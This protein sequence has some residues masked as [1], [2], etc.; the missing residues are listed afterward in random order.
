MKTALFFLLDK[1]ADWEV[2]YLASRLNVNLDWEVKTVSLQKDTSISSMGGFRTLIDYH[3][4]DLPMDADLLVLIGGNCWGLENIK[5][6]QL[7]DHFLKQGTCVAAICGAVDFLARYGH[8]NRFKHTGNTSYLWADY[9][10]YRNQTEFLSEQVVVDRNLITANGTAA[11]EFSE[12]I[13]KTLK[14]A[15]NEQIEKEHK[16]FAMGYYNYVEKYGNPFA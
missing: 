10:N 15:S 2:G 13:L 1:Y 11:I 9:E 6:S 8:L 7:I 3:V 14:F 12:Q 4:D 5:L 16:L